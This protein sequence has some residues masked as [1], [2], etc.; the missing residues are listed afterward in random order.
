[1]FACNSLSPVS[2]F[3]TVTANEKPGVRCPTLPS[4]GASSSSELLFSGEQLGSLL[5]AE[6]EVEEEEPTVN[7]EG[8]EA[9]IVTA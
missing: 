4:S 7:G 6:E 3:T 1:M 8:V 5:T 2:A 9:N